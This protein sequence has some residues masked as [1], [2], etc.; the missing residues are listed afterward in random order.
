[1]EKGTNYKYIVYCTTNKVNQKI[2]VGVHKTQNPEE[3]DSYLGCGVLASQP[4]TYSSPKTKFQ[5]AVKKYGVKSF[6]RKTLAI[7]NTSE[8]AYQME[9]DIVNSK[10]LERNDIYN[11]CLGG[12]ASIGENNKVKVYCYTLDG[13]FFKEF[14]SML[15]AGIEF[16]VDYSAISYAVR[17]KEKSCNY[18][19]STDKLE[20]LDLT[21]YSTINNNRIKTYVYDYSGLFYKEFNSQSEASKEL[22]I[23]HSSICSSIKLGT[24]TQN[25]YFSSEKQES[26]DKARS[27]QILKRKVYKY[28]KNGEFIEEFATQKDAELKHPFSNITKAIKLKSVCDNNFMW[29]LE[30]LVN[31]NIPKSS[32]GKRKRVGKYD[33]SGNLVKEYESATSAEKENGTSV[34]KVLKGTNKTHKG[35]LYKYLDN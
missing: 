5:Y 19:W 16:K 21:L 2:Y 32:V 35:H 14:N 23:S 12:C 10:F 31:F 22:G 30:K 18:Y 7:F 25:F 1:M 8:E 17:N 28:S 9:A 4:N 26:F 15:D 29:S 13:K 24:K 34:W 33:L 11:M 3:F 6:E 27:I 20:N